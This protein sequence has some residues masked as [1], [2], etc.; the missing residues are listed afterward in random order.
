MKKLLMKLFCPSAKTLAGF[1][2]Q[3]IA[4]KHNNSKE[5]IKDMIAKYAA[6]A[7]VATRISNRLA[8]MVMD[9]TIDQTET[10]ELQEMLTPIFEKALAL[11]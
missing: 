4:T 1:A 6:H 5:E 2:A 7:E 3:G 11:V 9:G 10:A 8:A